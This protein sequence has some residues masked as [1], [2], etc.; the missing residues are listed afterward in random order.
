MLQSTKRFRTTHVGSLPR[1]ADLMLF[2][3]TGRL[4]DNA[5]K[6][7]LARSVNDIVAMQRNAGI[8]TVSDGEFGK[9]SFMTY[10]HVRLSGFEAVNPPTLKKAFANT[11]EA[12]A[13]PEFYR[14]M[15]PKIPP[16][17]PIPSAMQARIC[18]GPIK[19]V[20]QNQLERDIANLKAAMAANGI[21]EG[22]MPSIAP[23]SV[24]DWF[25]NQFYKSD[26]EYLYAIADALRD[27]Y[28]AIVD[29][30]LILQI[31]DPHFASIMLW[32]PDWSVE[33][34]RRWAAARVESLN[35]ALRD[36]PEDRVR[37]HTCHSVD[38]APRTTDMGLRHVLDLT[39]SIKAGAYS[40]EGANPRH[41]HEFVLWDEFK[42]PYGKLIIPGVVTNS[43]FVVEHP[44]LVAQRL[45]RYAE[46]VGPEN[47]IAGTDCGF[48]TFATPA[49]YDLR[50]IKAKFEALAE[51]ARIA[52]RRF[53]S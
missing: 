3:P 47:V 27:E 10:A 32:R 31:D 45:V 52:S 9:E 6:D 16:G 30:G 18:S 37:H 15:E 24:E 22:F 8:D 4:N 38:A 39:L 17:A 21:E 5:A 51:G 13:F 26:E 46:R 12:I 20:G 43:S 53:W 35:Y 33:Q 14:A 29:S 1:P 50:I 34:A 49:G 19:Y 41:E 42:L 48:G 23:C 2:I 44:E 36:I 7:I 40:F 25:Q 28:R 11:R